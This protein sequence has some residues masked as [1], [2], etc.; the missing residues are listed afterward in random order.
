PQSLPFLCGRVLMQESSRFPP[1]RTTYSAESCSCTAAGKNRA[2]LR[3]PLTMPPRLR[4]HRRGALRSVAHLLIA[5]AAFTCR[6]VRQRGESKP[7]LCNSNIAA[8][9]H[10]YG[11]IERIDFFQLRALAADE[12]LVVVCPIG[13]SASLGDRVQH[14]QPRPIG[15]LAGALDLALDEERRV[16]GNFDG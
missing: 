14:G 9:M 13:E 3:L 5:E 2:A 4:Q 8:R 1:V 15:E 12:D 10:R 11:Q 6:D 7:P 16:N